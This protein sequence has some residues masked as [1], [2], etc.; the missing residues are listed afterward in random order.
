M[1]E[2]YTLY[3]SDISYFSGKLEGYLRYTE[4]PHRLVDCDQRTLVRIARKTGTQKMPAIEMD[5][6]LIHI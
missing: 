6:S 1:S 5:L 3:K 2:C 4:I